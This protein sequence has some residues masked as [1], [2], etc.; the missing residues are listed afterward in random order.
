MSTTVKHFL[1]THGAMPALSGQ[2]GALKAVLKASMVDGAGAQTVTISVTSGVATVT[3]PTAHGMAAPAVLLVAGATPAALNGEQLIAAAPSSTT[4]TYATTAVDGAA[5]GS[6]TARLAPA[7]WSEIFTG[8][9]LSALK[10]VAL[11]ASGCVFRLDDTGTTT[12][13]VVGYEQMSAVSSGL[14]AFPTEAQVSGG[15]Y[16]G[17]S[18]TANSTARPWALFADGQSFLF[19]AR[20]N[21]YGG[22][23]FGFGDLVGLQSGDAWCSA[24]FGTTSSSPF[25]TTSI[26]K[27][28]IAVGNAGTIPAAEAFVARAVDGNGGSQPLGKFSLLNGSESYSGNSGNLIAY[29]NLAGSGLVLAPVFAMMGS[30]VRGTI[31]GVYHCPQKVAGEF[32]MFELVPGTGE[33]EGRTFMALPV[34]TPT[35][36]TYT[37]VVFVDVTGPWR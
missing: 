33:W 27:G 11:E 22:A 32:A 4:L 8:T 35:V 15:L 28:D 17:K 10:P 31:A 37:G 19:W 2:A 20:T 6:I 30:V 36:T 21:T 23:L 24:L 3:F 9:S 18:A 1:S 26:L 12:A 14:N 5:T 13:R 16:W 25:S 7:G 29:P 34:G